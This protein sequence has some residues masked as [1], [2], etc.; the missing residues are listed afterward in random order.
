VAVRARA[1]LSGDV[2]NLPVERAVLVQL[3]PTGAGA[4]TGEV[5]RTDVVEAGDVVRL[6]DHAWPEA[7]QMMIVGRVTSV[8]PS[9]SEPLRS[10]IAVAPQFQIGQV[11]YATLLVEE[12]VVGAGAD[13]GDGAP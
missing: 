6:D 2:P 12:A 1:R 11:S 8:E 5:R 3:E 10:R 13:D 7:A 9:E 4:F